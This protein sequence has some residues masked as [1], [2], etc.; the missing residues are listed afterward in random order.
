MD[1]MI[2]KNSDVDLETMSKGIQRKILA[3]GGKIMSVE[4]HFRKDAIADLHTHPHEQIGYIIKGSLELEIE[5]K[6]RIIREGDS[7][8]VGSNIP[9][10]VIALEETT[11]LDV[12]TPQRE[13]FLR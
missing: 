2:V 13:D 10:G 12:F 5:S 4:V 8:Y 6:K 3:R 1:K 11:V 9:H 7:F